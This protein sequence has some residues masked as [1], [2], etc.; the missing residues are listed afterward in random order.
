M[1]QTPLGPL[2]FEPIF[3]S[4]LWGGRRL[5]PMFGA[6]PS[7]EPT[8]EAWILSDHGENHS[9]VAGG[10]L[11][12]ATLRELMTAMPQR[13]LGGPAPPHGRF[14]L[15]LKFIDASQPLSVQVHP[16]DRLAKSMSPPAGGLDAGLGKTEAWVILEAEPHSRI[17]AGLGRGVTRNDLLV[18]LKGETV[19]EKLHSFQPRPGDCVFLPAGTIHAIGGG[20]LLFEVQQTSDI[21]YRLHDWGRVDAKTGRP[22]DLHVEQSLRCIDFERG[23]CAPVPV[24]VESSEPVICEKL[25]SCTYFTLRRFRGSKP[26]VVGAAG[27]CRIVV[28]IGGTTQILHDFVRYP[29]RAGDV[30]L[31]PAE[32]G[33]C[34]CFPMGDVTLL[35]CGFPE[36]EG[37]V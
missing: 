10:P 4:A 34:Q 1:P 7:A 12:G 16:N 21:T 20:L 22:R 2:H 24:T 28:G 31:L 8:G 3:K 9:R 33:V 35:E 13:I 30:L 18:A 19:A 14:P 11:R 29:L 26:F 17:Y 32:T 27:Q 25:V 37:D 5:R 6:T 15:L 23:P 36:A